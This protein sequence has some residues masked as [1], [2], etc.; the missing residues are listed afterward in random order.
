MT[1]PA[2]TPA[3][4]QSSVQARGAGKGSWA[5][6]F[7]IPLRSVWKG[8]PL[9]STWADAQVCFGVFGV[10]IPGCS[11]QVVHERNTVRMGMAVISTVVF[12]FW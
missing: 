3:F 1:N 4:Q 6:R 2:Y 11:E 12:F 5:L 8:L 10:G 9:V 7:H